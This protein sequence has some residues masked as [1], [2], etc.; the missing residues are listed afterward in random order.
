MSGN[1]PLADPPLS[2]ALEYKRW[3]GWRDKVYGRV[4]PNRRKRLLAYARQGL[5][6]HGRMH[7]TEGPNRSDLFSRPRGS[8]SGAS[9]DCSQYAASMAHWAGVKKVTAQDWTG[10]LYTKGEL[11]ADAVD[12]CYV[13]FGRSPGV[14]MGIMW[15]RNVVGFGEQQGP[16]VNTLASLIAYFAGHGHPGY[17]FRDITR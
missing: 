8:F 15:G 13:I 7:Y 17:V 4:H 2:L 11:L 14:H 3:H 10:T 5:A 9:A 1:P 12:G 16:D 6:Y